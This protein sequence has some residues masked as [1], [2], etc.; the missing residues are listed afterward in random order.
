VWKSPVDTTP[1]VDLTPG[2]QEANEMRRSND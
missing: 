2:R 1:T